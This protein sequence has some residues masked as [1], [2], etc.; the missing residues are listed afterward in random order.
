MSGPERKSCSTARYRKCSTARQR[1]PAICHGTARSPTAFSSKP[2]GRGARRA[3]LSTSDAD[4]ECSPSTWRSRGYRT[5]GVDLMPRALEM[6][7]ERARNEGADVEW[8]NADLLEWNT[9]QRFDLILDSGWLHSLIGGD[10]RRYK[11]KLLSW[12]APR[13]DYILGHFGKRG[14]LDWRPVGPARRTRQ[15]VVRF[16]SPSSRSWTT[17]RSS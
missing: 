16:F 3:W 9:Q 10:R 14:F 4:R 12:L 1:P 5:T 11:E 7:K 6:A 15:Q 17:R 8:V 13:G 2:S